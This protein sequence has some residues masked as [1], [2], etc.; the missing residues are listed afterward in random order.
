MQLL[1]NPRGPYPTCV[2]Y[3]QRT[4][5][6]RTTSLCPSMAVY[7]PLLL[8]TTT[9]AT[10]RALSRSAKG[11][12]Q[13]REKCGAAAASVARSAAAAAAEAAPS[14]AALPQLLRRRGISS[15][16]RGKARPCP[17]ACRGDRDDSSG[18]MLLCLVRTIMTPV[19]HQFSEPT[20]LNGGEIEEVSASF[21][22]PGCVV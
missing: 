7:G 10:S 6:L 1:S 20:Q 22:P 17:E 5:L 14:V 13:R 9:S 12:A 4:S 15:S 21:P 19:L 16:A 2:V 11:A 18:I 3:T 8:R